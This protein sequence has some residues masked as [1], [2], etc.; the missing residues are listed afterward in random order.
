MAA[1]RE[2]GDLTAEEP[3]AKAGL[4][5]ATSAE[6]GAAT[7]NA[8]SKKR[9]P[10]KRK[11]GPLHGRGM[12]GAE[13]FPESG[14]RLDR[15]DGADGHATASGTILDHGVGEARE[16]ERA[17]RWQRLA[18]TAGAVGA[19]CGGADGSPRAG[20]HGAP[21]EARAPLSEEK[22]D[23]LALMTGQLSE[24]AVLRYLRAASSRKALLAMPVDPGG[25]DC[26]DM[27]DIMLGM[28]IHCEASDMGWAF[29][30]VVVPSRMAGQR[31][32]FRC[33]GMRPVAVEVERSPQG[34]RLEWTAS[35]WKRVEP[36]HA[37]TTQSRLRQ[38]ALVKRMQTARAAWDSRGPAS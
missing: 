29:G 7:A 15:V 9:K 30:T 31:G 22:A 13:A 24:P 1:S 35:S 12:A 11:G 32:C 26:K 20:A 3:T 36:L 27:L 34:D 23:L 33:Q 4:V 18:E 37:S 5:L 28:V 6:E 14:Q 8:P 25:A 17:A 21:D 38:R 16:A 2:E 19:S 10:K